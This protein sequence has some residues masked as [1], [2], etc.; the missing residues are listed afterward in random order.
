MSIAEIRPYQPWDT[1]K[2]IDWLST[3]KKSE[4]MTKLTHQEEQLRVIHCVWWVDK[5]LIPLLT[6]LI[7]AIS[8]T[9]LKSGDIVGA[10]INNTLYSAS[11]KKAQYIQWFDSI[12]T[13]WNFQDLSA[14]HIQLLQHSVLCVTMSDFPD[15]EKKDLLRTLSQTNSIVL[16]VLGHE[17]SFSPVSGKSYA[18]EWVDLVGR[19]VEDYSILVQ[20][21]IQS[22][23]SFMQSIQWKCITIHTGSDPLA[24]LSKQRVY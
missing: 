9:S 23:R 3:A 4:L 10:M 1:I 24:Q 11:R 17:E 5:H 20:K 2:Q 16:I 7:A 18:Y 21:T 22:T 6:S 19:S 15:E 8:Y 12:E 13:L 14:V